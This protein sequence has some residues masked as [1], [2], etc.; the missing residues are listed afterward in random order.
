MRRV[1]LIVGLIACGVIALAANRI[2]MR[3]QKTVREIHEAMI[4]PASDAI[5][6]ASNN[7]PEDDAAW[8][9]VRK[10]AAVLAE[11]GNLL[12][13]PSLA[14]DNGPWMMMSRAL[15]DAAAAALKGAE[16]KDPDALLA[17]TD[18]ITEACMNCHQPYRDAGR[19]MLKNPN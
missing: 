17:S 10:N 2:F 18:Q 16:E 14:R 19:P 6:D 7:E 15:V 13:G 8:I 11:S 1:T 3:E 12:M 4:T 5:F 9:A